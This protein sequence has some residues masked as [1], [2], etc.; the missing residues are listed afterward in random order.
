MSFY[1]H[2]VAYV[3]TY[4]SIKTGFLSSLYTCKNRFQEYQLLFLWT[5]DLCKARHLACP[6]PVGLPGSTNPTRQ[7]IIENSTG[8]G[9]QPLWDEPTDTAHLMMLCYGRPHALLIINSPTLQKIILPSSPRIFRNINHSLYHLFTIQVLLQVLG[10]LRMND[11]RMYSRSW[12]LAK[13]DGRCW[14]SV[15]QSTLSNPR[16]AKTYSQ[17][18]KL[19]RKMLLSPSERIGAK[20]LAGLTREC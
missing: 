18:R 13:R 16:N 4:F 9:C 17:L 20:E 2:V 8:E 10:S 12:R 3:Q 5:T 15:S 11:M 1:Q 19:V 6:A 7:L 14:P